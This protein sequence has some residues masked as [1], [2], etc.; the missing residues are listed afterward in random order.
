[1]RLGMDG[2]QIG[3]GS[4]GMVDGV[5]GTYHSGQWTGWRWRNYVSYDGTI[6]ENIQRFDFV[7]M[8]RA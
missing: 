5:I 2:V 1:M 4:S 7:A 6:W 3:F 8:V